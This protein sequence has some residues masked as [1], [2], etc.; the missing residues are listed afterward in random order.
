MVRAIL[1]ADDGSQPGL[2][3]ARHPL[4]FVP[5]AKKRI[6]PLEHLF[7]D[8]DGWP[9]QIG[10]P[11]TRMSRQRPSANRVMNLRTR[12]NTAGRALRQARGQ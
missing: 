10:D 1:V 12:S 11:I 9:S 4:H 6:H 5:F 7:R 3:I 2:P 8:A